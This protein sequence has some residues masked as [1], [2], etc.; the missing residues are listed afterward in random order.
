MY[1]LDDFLS[2]TMKL[3]YA[4]RDEEY[5]PVEENSTKLK[6]QH[7]YSATRGHCIVLKYTKEVSKLPKI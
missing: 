5:N 4:I 1:K 6:R 7:V 2:N 3:H